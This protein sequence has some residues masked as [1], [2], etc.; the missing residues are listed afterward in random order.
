M[1]YPKLA[2]GINWFG[3]S[4]PQSGYGVVNLEYST[5]IQRQ[6]VEVYYGWE[7]RKDFLPG[8]WDQLT[9][10]QK[11]LLEKP[12][13]K[14]RLGII[15][16]TPQLFHK[17]TSDFRIGYTMVENTKIGKKWV[18]LCNQMDAIFVPN[19]FLIDIFKEGGVNK[20]IKSVKQGID[21][22][23]FPYIKRKKKEKFIFGTIGYM[24][25]RKNWQDMVQAFCSEFGHDE[26]VEFWIKNSNGYF[27][28]TSFTDPRIKLINRLYAFEEI[29]KLYQY[30]DCF[31]CPSHA[32]G[33]GLPPREAMATGLPTILTNWSGLVEI[34]NPIF[35]YPLTPIAID[36]PDI[37][38]EDQPGFMARIDVAELMYWMR[39]V[40]EHPEEA[41]RKG[42]LASDFIHRKFNWDTCA[43]DLLKKLEEF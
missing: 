39:W 11:E 35:N 30:F 36:H 7:R 38:G 23:K 15:K 6:G 12:F 8:L 17:N 21:S 29:Q 10:E 31:L 43:Q 22:K 42:K 2:G 5:A 32:E 34:C 27:N 19:S 20:P 25:D 26:P 18:D 28:H 41:E 14:K 33:S 13:Q 1:N 37:R 4:N 9:P 3:W 24:D 40:Y 16:T